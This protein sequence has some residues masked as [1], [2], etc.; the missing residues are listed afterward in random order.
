M[1]SSA[2]RSKDKDDPSI[3]KNQEIIHKQNAQRNH[4]M[5][6]QLKR[7]DRIS[8]L[9]GTQ[10]NG[11]ELSIPEQKELQGLLST[12]NGN[13][14]VGDFVE[15]YSSLGFS[16]EHVAFKSSHNQVFARLITYC[17]S[18]HADRIINVFYLDGPCGGTTEALLMSSS[19]SL[20]A[21]ARPLEA[22]QC[23]T[24]NRHASTCRA[25]R[26]RFPV[27]HVQHASAEHALL[28]A[29]VPFHA[30]YFDACG[31]H[32]PMI[33][34]MMR[35]A[36]VPEEGESVSAWQPPV[37]IGFSILGGGRD[38]VDK[39]QEVVQALVQLVKPMKCRVAR[40]GDDPTIYG[41][42]NV[43]S[44]VKVHSLTMTTW[45]MIERDYQCHA[46]LNM[47]TP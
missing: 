32:V 38:C 4:L 45:L 44:L 39:E 10:R 21:A 14:E 12:N 31:G 43:A 20:S 30:F 8:F 37:A 46:R 36:L 17:Q 2:H 22:H 24:A 13:E 5:T 47:K 1:S 18:K 19:S 23:Y 16:E 6:R 35:A 29:S 3:S 11:V 41:I 7:E 33:V 34:D 25:L 26:K 42:D 28:Q 15:Q 9:E 27:V 40:V